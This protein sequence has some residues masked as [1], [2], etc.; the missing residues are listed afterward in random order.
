VDRRSSL[1]RSF[2]FRLGAAFALVALVGATATVLVVNAAFASRL[3]RFLAQQQSSRL[4]DIGA[5]LSRAYSGNGLWDQQALA[6]VVPTVGQGTVQVVTPN[7]DGVWEWDGHSMDWD[8]RWMEG[9]TGTGTQPPQQPPA[10]GQPTPS[11]DQ[12]DHNSGQHDEQTPP[13]TT[14]P[15]SGREDER[16]PNWQSHDQWGAASTGAMSIQSAVLVAATVPQTTTP[17]DTTSDLGPAQR[18]PIVVNGT[19]VAT[20]LVRLPEV[21]ALPETMRFRSQVVRLLL[22][23]GA[24]GALVALGLGVLFARRTSKPVR[25]ATGAARALAAGDRTVRVRASRSDEF[26]E[27][28]EAFNSMADAV[29][30]EE[31]LRQGFAAEVA[32]ELRT[33]LTILRSQVEGMRVGVLEPTPEA[34]TS[35]DEEVRRMSRLVADLQILGSADAAGFSLEPADTDLRELV[36]QAVREVA[37]LFDGSEVR[38]DT[39][40]EPAT[41]W[42]DQVRVGQILANLLSNAL[43]YTP[44]GGLVRVELTSEPD[45]AVLRVSDSGPGIPADELPHVFERFFRGRGARS[46]GSGIGLT[47]VRELVEAHG[48]TVQVASEEGHGTTFTVC[49]PPRSAPSTNGAARRH[50]T[51]PA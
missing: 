6:A 19:V 30:S 26:G 36:E 50:S 27:L 12:R 48:G 2:S 13:Q 4:A 28:A 17:A 37:E 25:E 9:G 44:P 15:S 18:V 8:Q 14:T 23:G 42:V 39:R 21:T 1:L 49:L 43:K 7:G 41:A 47:V 29:D 38:L 5:A 24:L 20:A 35:L 46:S 32:H 45:W 40:L 11:D 10:T 16:D 31:R 34:L 3:D 22:L 33:P 51:A